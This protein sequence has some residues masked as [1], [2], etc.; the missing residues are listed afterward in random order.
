MMRWTNGRVTIDGL[1]LHYHRSSPAETAGASAPA[2]PVILAHGLTDNGRCW[3]RLAAELAECFDVISPD[4]RGHGLSDA[5]EA[6]YGVREHA[7][8]LAGLTEALG[9]SPAAFVGH[10]MGA[11]SV[12]LLAASYPARVACLVLEDPP[13]RAEGERRSPE[14]AAQTEAEWRQQIAARKQSSREELAA[15]NRRTRPWWH[16]DEH[17]AWADAKH[18]VDPNALSYI[19][20]RV[21]WPEVVPGIGCPALLLTGDPERGAIVTPDT[22]RAICRMNSRFQWSRIGGAGHGIRRDRF[23]Q[24]SDAVIGFLDS[25]YPPA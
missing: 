10:S 1:C 12:A 16:E 8:D 21:P 20:E 7:A 24:Y 18:Q 4:A 11:D 3:D 9:L 14:Q 13:W 15:E 5:P 22:A 23:D 17:G 2:P 6:G 19:R 25:C